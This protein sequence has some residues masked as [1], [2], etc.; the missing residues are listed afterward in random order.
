MKKSFNKRVIFQPGAYEAFQSGINKMVNLVRPTLGP[1]PR[2]VAIEKNSRDSLP[3]LLDDGGV[4]VRRVIAITNKDEDMGAMF[5]RHVLWRQHELAGD[6]VVTTATLFQSVFNQAIKY[7]VAGGNPMLVRG[8]LEE[9]MRVVL[10]ELKRMAVPLDGEKQIAQVAES[11]CYDPEM[12]NV[13]GEAFD[14]IGEFGHL[15]IRGGHKPKIER[16][17]VEGTF[18]TM[19]LFSPDMRNDMSNIRAYAEDPRVFISDFTIEDPGELNPLL[20]LAIESGIKNLVIIV[21]HLADPVVASLLKLNQFQN[22][23]SVFAVNAPMADEGRPT[24]LE[25]ISILTGGK[26]FIKATGDSID[27]VKIEDF[28]HVRRAWADKEYFGFSGGKG[29]PKAVRARIE[30][31]KRRHALAEDLE[32]RKK[33]RTRIGKLLGGSATIYAGGSGEVEINT[34]KEQLERTSEALRSAILQGVLPGGGAALLACRPAVKR[35]IDQAKVQEEK[36]AYRF[37]LRALEEPTRGILTNAGF[38]PDLWIARIAKAG[39]GF[40][41]DV[42]TG[43]VVDMAQAGIVDSAGVVSAAVR[44]AFASAALAM[45]VDVLIHH[46][47]PELGLNT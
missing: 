37:I 12:A 40:G 26:L 28:G 36:V 41:F 47:K 30:E 27:S 20:Q 22:K 19:K 14:Y 29:S 31:L 23:F 18:Y 21:N 38:D 39:S 32:N 16:E 25:D 10:D 15:E 34:R 5:I 7:I 46:K 4:I 8:Y 42:R 35:K 45:T 33:Y 2:V 43:K 9:G 24:I 17:Y 6:G 3:E 44:S 11:V 1:L 13:L